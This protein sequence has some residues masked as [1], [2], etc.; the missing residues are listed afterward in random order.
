MSF[1]VAPLTLTGIVLGSLV[2]G[3]GLQRLVQLVFFAE[4]KQEEEL[5]APAAPMTYGEAMSARPKE[6]VPRRRRKKGPGPVLLSGL[7]Y[8]EYY[9]TG[10]KLTLQAWRPDP[11]HRLA[12]HV[13]I[14][15][16]P[17]AQAPGNVRRLAIDL[18][19][20]E[21]ARIFELKDG[22]AVLLAV[23]DYEVKG[24]GVIFKD[25]D[26]SKDIGIDDNTLYVLLSQSNDDAKKD[27]AL[28][29]A[30]S[31]LANG[32]TAATTIDQAEGL[33]EPTIIQRPHQDTDTFF[34][35]TTNFKAFFSSTT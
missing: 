34:K 9:S 16:I 8:G 13:V 19:T 26:Y 31:R 18:E 30:F 24:Q 10:Q 1:P 5:Q 3:I 17:K 25:L 22:A 6:D 32:L 15:L 23:R 21:A 11:S 2:V 35:Q 27:D 33:H 12:G 29:D 20:V 4:V 28:K 14:D 7:R